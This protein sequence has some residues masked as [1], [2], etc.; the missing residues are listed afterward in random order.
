MANNNS[1]DLHEDFLILEEFICRIYGFKN[2]VEINKARLASFMK[3][4]KIME[5]N[6]V[7]R[8]PKS[9][10]DGSSLPPCQSELK[11]HFLRTY[12]IA[13]LWGN[14]FRTVPNELSPQEYGWEEIENKY[15]FK[16]FEGDQLPPTISEIM[17]TSDIREGNTNILSH[18]K[19]KV[20]NVSNSFDRRTNYN[21]KIRKR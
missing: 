19:N 5:N 1:I 10:I 4:Y 17:L 6:D 15:F 18:P 16:W 21:K 7:F 13:K 11:Q 3:T 2:V 14:A 9:N 20:C 8:L 12:Y